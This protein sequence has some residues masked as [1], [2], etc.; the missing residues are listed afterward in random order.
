MDFK[1]NKPK[2]LVINKNQFGHHTDYYK[3]CEYLKDEFDITF[4][5][6][7]LNYEL[8]EMEG[9]EVVYVSYK[10][11]YVL[12]GI[13]FLI[14]AIKK[15]FFH[16]GLVFINYFEKCE[17]LKKIFPNKKMILD[18][19]TLA[20]N[21]DPVVRKR[22]DES[23]KEACNIF[24]YVTI[25]S[26]GLQEKL[27]LSASK[28]SVIPLGSDCI[29]NCD[30][31]FINLKLL[32]VGT[33]SG[34]NISQTILGL[35]IFI[36]NNPKVKITYDIIGDG[37]DFETINNLVI[38]LNLGKIVKMHGRIPHFKLKPFF[39][40]S[41]VGVSYV[42]ITDYYQYQPP[43]KTYEYINSGMACVATNTFENQK[44]INSQNGV[45]CNDSPESFALSIEYIS[46]NLN[47]YNSKTIKNTLLNNN[48]FTIVDQ[49]LKPV[50]NNFF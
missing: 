14:I 16:R 40:N 46:Q 45:L 27:K 25:I 6:F 30:K 35:K 28:C 29:S 48:W 50:L 37:F 23:L 3:F 47:F 7:Y 39:D 20:V 11:H 31:V 43:T 34:R 38:D 19:R 17:L 42:P 36:N 2:I 21:N 26:E 18:I 24:D 8:L 1:T 10:G 5:C 12:R 49:S 44:I 22:E 4:L 33:L 32:Y 15:I 41:N 9:I 13:M